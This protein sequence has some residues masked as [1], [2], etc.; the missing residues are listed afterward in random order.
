MSRRLAGLPLWAWV[1]AAVAV[2]TGGYLL[3]QNQGGPQS[4]T[5]P[6]TA[7]PPSIAPTPYVSA[8][9]PAPPAGNTP[10][11]G[12][13]PGSSRMVQASGQQPWWLYPTVQV[14]Q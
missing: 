4:S 14:S 5:Q 11:D 3:W 12:F 13:S 6:M 2:A 8:A 7:S 10:A 9:N 1:V